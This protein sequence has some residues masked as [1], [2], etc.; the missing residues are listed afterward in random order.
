MKGYTARKGNRWYAGIYQ[1]LDPVTGREQ[2]SWHAAGASQADAEELARKLVKEIRG[3]DDEGRSLTFGAYLTERWLPSKQIE[4]RPT[5]SAGY[6]RNVKLHILPLLGKI[7]I[8]RLTC[9]HIEALYEAKLRPTDGSRPLS[10]KTVLELHTG[11]RGAIAGAH[12]NAS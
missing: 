8:G 3:R 5:T 12:R 4:L 1:G 10:A 6:N 11:I 7:K 2:R 9:D